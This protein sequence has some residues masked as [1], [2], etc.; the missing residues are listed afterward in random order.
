MG[1]MH[2]KYNGLTLKSSIDFLRIINGNPNDMQT[3]YT[4]TMRAIKGTHNPPAI[5]TFLFS[6]A[7]QIFKGQK[8][9]IVVRLGG[10]HFLKSFLG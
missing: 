3:I 10:F 1:F 8:L 2:Q 6:R 7:S 9:E 5:L 4:T